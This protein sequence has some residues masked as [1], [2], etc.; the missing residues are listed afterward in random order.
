MIGR[1]YSSIF[2]VT[3]WGGTWQKLETFS[4]LFSARGSLLRHMIKSGVRPF[5]RRTWT[6]C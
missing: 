1:F 4:L 5:P 3:C 6:L 2:E